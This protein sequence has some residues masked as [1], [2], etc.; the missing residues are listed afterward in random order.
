MLG[1]NLA[2][3][4]VH[5]VDVIGRPRQMTR[6][7][8]GRGTAD[9][10]L[11]RELE[12]TAQFPEILPNFFGVGF[13]HNAVFANEGNPASPRSASQMAW[14]VSRSGQRN[15]LSRSFCGPQWCCS[16]SRLS[17]ISRRDR[18]S[19]SCANLVFNCLCQIIW[20]DLRGSFHQLPQVGFALCRCHH[21]IESISSQSQT[22]VGR[23]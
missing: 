1:P 13:L 16:A 15:N 4:F 18:K 10:N 20:I 9:E 23:S 12:L 8:E 17:R 22:T 11:D 2:G 21:F 3:D 5:H 14:I 7:N 19:R 6:Q